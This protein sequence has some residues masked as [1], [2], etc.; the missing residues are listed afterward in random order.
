[1]KKMSD[2]RSIFAL[3]ALFNYKSVFICP[4]VCLIFI[5]VVIYADDAQKPNVWD[6][7]LRLQKSN[8]RCI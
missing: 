1:M 3:V 7:Q 6:L 5:F 8:N 4:S 2:L